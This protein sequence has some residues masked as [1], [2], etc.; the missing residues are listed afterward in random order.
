M[1]LLLILVSG[2]SCAIGTLR[3]IADPPA[4]LT[5]PLLCAAI[6]LVTVVGA[7]GLDHLGAG[8]AARTEARYAY[9]LDS[10]CQYPRPSYDETPGW[11]F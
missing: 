9:A 2:V 4:R 6:A 3:L 11:F 5:A 8:I 1:T 10:D 7:D